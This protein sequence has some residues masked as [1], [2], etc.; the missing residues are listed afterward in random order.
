MNVGNQTQTVSV[1]FHLLLQVI[2]LLFTSVSGSAGKLL[3]AEEEPPLQLLVRPPEGDH[4]AP[5][6]D[7]PFISSVIRLV[8]IIMMIL[9]NDH[10]SFPR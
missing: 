10:I 4:G 8:T 1:N 5:P 9:C 6:L 3:A 2:I 7:S